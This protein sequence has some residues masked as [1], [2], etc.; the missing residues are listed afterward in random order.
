MLALH[1]EAQEVQF[2][3]HGTGNSGSVPSVECLTAPEG[4]NQCETCMS[5]LRPDG[6]KNIRRNT[7]AVL[8]IARPDGEKATIVIDVGKTFLSSALEWFPKYGLRKIDGV[9]IT[10]PHA[11]AMNG[12]DD[13]R[14]WTLGGAIQHHIDVYTSQATLTQVKRAFPYLVSKEFASGGGDVPQFKWH[15][16]EANKPFVIGDTKIK[17]TPFAVHHGRLFS[18]GPS[19]PGWLPTPASSHPSTPR[20]VPSMPLPADELLPSSIP[21]VVHP[22]FCLGFIILDI[23]YMSDVSHIP[24]TAWAVIEATKQRPWSLFVVDCLRIQPHTSHFGLAQAVTAARRLGGKELRTYLIGMSHDLPHS[25]LVSIGKRLELAD[26]GAMESDDEIV[27]AALELVPKG[28][29]L[30]I[31]PAYDG[32]RLFLS[33]D[34]SVQHEDD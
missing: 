22:Y 20:T 26:G 7:G 29:P 32:L 28:P 14:G 21:D 18:S 5:T 9:I 2:I 16:I 11:D 31:R 10:H 4:A 6:K 17:V 33:D 15:I 1:E 8:R 3:F 23:V 19:P 12:L 25:T 27:K 30:W 13:L 34:G 24:E